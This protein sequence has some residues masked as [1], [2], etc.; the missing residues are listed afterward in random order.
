MSFFQDLKEPNWPEQT[1]ENKG[2]ADILKL[3]HKFLD[4]LILYW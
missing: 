4:P 2:V 1:D 3:A